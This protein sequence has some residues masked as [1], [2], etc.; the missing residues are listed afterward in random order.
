MP[1][2][3]PLITRPATRW[4]TLCA[5][6]VMIEPTIQTIYRGRLELERAVGD[7]WMGITIPM[8]SSA[9]SS[10]RVYQKEIQLPARQSMSQLTWKL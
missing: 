8:L 3:K 5:L 10:V 6:Q 7:F 2:Q 1:T 9:L 4:P